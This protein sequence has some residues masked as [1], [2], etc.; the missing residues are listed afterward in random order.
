MMSIVGP[1]GIAWSSG[2]CTVAH[3]AAGDASWIAG[4]GPH[5]NS[6]A[7]AAAADGTIE[8][9]ATASATAMADRRPI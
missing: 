5:R 1:L 3:R 6:C 9:T 2:T 8:P 7:G 4:H